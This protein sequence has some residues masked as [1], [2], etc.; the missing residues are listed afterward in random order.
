MSSQIRVIC[1]RCNGSGQYH[2][3]GQCFKCCGQGTL[4][5]SERNAKEWGYQSVQ[6]FKAAEA[7]SAKAAAESKV[8]DIATKAEE[9]IE[10]VAQIIGFTGIIDQAALLEITQQVIDA[11]HADKSVSGMA[12]RV[13]AEYIK[14]YNQ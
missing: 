13:G 4:L 1:K 6:A 8:Q 10:K 3:F 7:A 12:S 9:A 5:M 11:P 2:H 14:Q